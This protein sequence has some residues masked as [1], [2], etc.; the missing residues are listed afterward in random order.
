MKR[1]GSSGK[2]AEGN[3]ISR[4]GRPIIGK[5]G[6]GL[7][8]VAQ[9]CNKFSVISKRKGK[10]TYFHATVD[11]KQFGEVEKESSYQQGRGDINLGTYEI[12][13]GLNDEV[14]SGRHYTKIIMEDI[15][16][17]F[18]NKLIQ[19]E[20]RQRFRIT[21]KAA[22]SERFLEF[23]NDIKSKKF[24]EIAQYDQL[25]WELGLLCPVE[26]I[27]NGPLPDNTI[28]R[29]EISRLEEYNFKVI[30]DGYEIRKPIQF[31][32]SEDLQKEEADYKT[33]PHISFNKQ[34]GETR[35]RFNGY[36]FHQR[37]RILPAE[38]QGILIR[39][40]GVAVGTYDRT[41]LHYPKAE[42]PMFNQISSEINVEEGLE[43]AL[44]ID[45]NSFNETHQ[46]YLS[47]Q[48]FLWDYLGGDNGV[49]KDIRRR[50]KKRQETL[51]K[52]EAIQGL[53]R[54]QEVIKEVL[55]LNIKV[56]RKKAEGE[57]LYVFNKREKTLIFF[58]NSFWSRN[59]KE[60]LIQEKIMLA[61]VAAKENSKSMETFEKNLL[62]ILSRGK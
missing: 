35:L 44:N 46:H 61:I 4:T 25:I 54:M 19:E 23:I 31:P 18:R 10:K 5:I 40:K 37:K 2:R 13:E 32:T 36:I 57:T 6:I 28:I 8:A 29:K 43:E 12:E 33:Y 11:L 60:R 7:L 58:A 51:R 48:E 45:R 47:L 59:Q 50:S 3:L 22:A 26:Y 62:L 17:G 14:G 55:G 24:N 52:K 41:F 53:E 27:E 9:I 15:K 34:V 30:V 42:G 38:L 20:T 56:E 16:E 21:E 1:I 49:F 39:I